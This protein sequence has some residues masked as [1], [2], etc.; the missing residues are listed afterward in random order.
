MKK[1]SILSLIAIALL[2]PLLFGCTEEIVPPRDILPTA[3]EDAASEPAG[4]PGMAFDV[5]LINTGESDAI[6]LQT[7]EGAFLVDTGLKKQFDTLS[8]A[9]SRLG[10]TEL[11]AVII[12]HGHKDHIGGLKKLLETYPVD[13]IYTS[14]LDDETFSDKEIKTIKTASAEHITV[15]QGDAFA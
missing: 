2:V 10:V 4:R 8:A 13:T 1:H 3:D 6:L 7:E 15:K 5:T 14:A 11:S 12:T 9:L